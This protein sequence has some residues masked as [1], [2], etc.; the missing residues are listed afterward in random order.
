MKL[1]KVCEDL[2][3]FA[4]SDVQRNYLSAVIKYGDVS[5][6]AKGT[7]VA[8]A[9]IQSAVNKVRKLAV[10]RGYSPAHKMDKPLPEGFH[11]KRLSTNYDAEGNVRQQWVIGQPNKD[12]EIRRL[13]EAAQSVF[14]DYKGHSKYVSKAPKGYYETESITVYPMGD[15]H[16]GMYAWSEETG[17]DFDCE[18]AERD[19]TNAIQKLVQRSPATDTAVILN[20]GDFFH[21]DNM[22]NQTARSGNALDVDSR[23]QRVLRLGVQAMIACVYAALEKHN[24][25]IVRNMTG[26]HDDHSSHFLAIALDM[27]FHNNERVVVDTAPTKFWYYRHGKVLIGSAHGDTAK[28]KDLPGVMA[29]DKAQDWGQTEHRYWYTG[30]IHTA[31]KQEFH[32]CVWESFRTLAAKD[33]WHTS[34]GYRSGRDMQSIVLH[35]DHGEIERHTVNITQL[36]KQK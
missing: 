19:L 18:I 24:K 33:A 15:P 11:L 23:W 12:E 14:E 26:N 34:M 5:K 16:I 22:D 32:G 9:R 10:T 17:E 3:Q 7:G 36:R 1:K 35:E 21:A 28:P 4:E 2:I 31:N 8:R 25:I 30:H 13:V 6:A 29:A 20:L 27:Y